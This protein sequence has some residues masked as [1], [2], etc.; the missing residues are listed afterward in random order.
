VQHLEKFLL[1]IAAFVLAACGGVSAASP[2]G[3]SSVN[4]FNENPVNQQMVT[5]GVTPAPLTLPNNADG[6]PVVARVNG[7]EITLPEFQSTLTRYEQQQPNVADAS[8]LQ[9]AV[10]NTMIEQVLIEQAAVER[11][12]SVSEEELDAEIQSNITLAGSESAWQDWLQTNQYTAEEFRETLRDALMTGR[13]LEVVTQDLEG[14]VAHVHARHI[15]VETEAEAADLLNRIGSG[16]DF[17]SLAAQYSLDE[18]T[19]R[20]G[21]DLGWFTE[22]EL[23][24]PALARAA[25]AL[26]P[27]MVTGPIQTLLGYH[28]IQTLERE[29]R[30]ISEDR[31]SDVM[32][33]RF[34]NWVDSLVATATIER[35]L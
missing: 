23:L 30:P 15:L 33:A 21:G 11:Q 31:L 1:L 17:A 18:T 5:L 9:N 29:N 7:V 12:I 19:A 28:I 8:V 25:F 20:Q 10:L 14:D 13:V 22:D 35:Y 16:E 32:Q 26:E 3:N 2:T 27:N 6:V 4:S 34:E 24:E